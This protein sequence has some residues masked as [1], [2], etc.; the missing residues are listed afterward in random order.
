MRTLWQ[1]TGTFG[2]LRQDH[3]LGTPRSPPHRAKITSS[4]GGLEGAGAFVVRFTFGRE[5]VEEVRGPPL[6][7]VVRDLAP[8]RLHAPRLFLRAGVDGR[9]DGVLHAVDAVSYTHLR[10]HETV[11]DF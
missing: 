6:D 1:G 7:V 4:T 3:L 2:L 8:H 11:L 9:K 5:F 10:A